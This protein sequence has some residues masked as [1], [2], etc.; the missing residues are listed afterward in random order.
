[1]DVGTTNGWRLNDVVPAREL[2][3][4]IDAELPIEPLEPS[5]RG[6][7]A[8]AGAT[9][10]GM[11]RS[12]SS[13]R[14]P[15]R[16]AATAAARASPPTAAS[17]PA[18]FRDRRHGPARSIAAGADDAALAE[19]L[20]G[21]WGAREDRYSELRAGNTQGLERVEMSFIGG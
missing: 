3:E 16:S 21:V 11:A 15:H 14:S 20:R 13:P 10:T 2:I 7:V 9:V 8:S 1:M 17:T 12:G 4:R 6:E 19:L 18:L 5:Y